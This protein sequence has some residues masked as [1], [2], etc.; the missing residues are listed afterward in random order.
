MT[1]P[2]NSNEFTVNDLNFKVR[3]IDPFKQFHIVRRLAPILSELL[4][5]L[6]KIKATM[7]GEEPGSENMTEEEKWQ[8]IGEIAQPL[9][10]G[11]SKLNDADSDKVLYSLLSGVEIQQGPGWAPVSDGSIMMFQNLELPALL[12]IAGRSFMFNMAGFFSILP[13]V[14]PGGS[15]KG[16]H[17]K[18]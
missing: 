18:P 16:K 13:Q 17:L 1:T 11:L 7:K 12:Q 6:G 14:S 5:S 4:P 10:M 3:K 15:K 8:Q 2:T 9:L